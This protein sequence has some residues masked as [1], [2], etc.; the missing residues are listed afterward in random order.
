MA[1]KQSY[2]KDLTNEKKYSILKNK[3]RYILGLRLLPGM[4]F[5]LVNILAGLTSVE[6][7]TFIWTT[8]VGIFPSTVVFIF[9]GNGLK[10]INDFSEFKTAKIIVPGVI[11][12]IIVILTVI[13]RVLYNKNKVK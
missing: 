5:F 8:I 2:G 9:A 11:I 4:P 6:L 7:Y 3:V 13:G 10:T 12:V 1:E